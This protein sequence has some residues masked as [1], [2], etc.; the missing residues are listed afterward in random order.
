MNSFS[1]F[2][3]A[4]LLLL[5]SAACPT[6]QAGL[7]SFE[8]G[9]GYHISLDGGV[10]SSQALIDAGEF[11]LNGF[12]PTAEYY[13]VSLAAVAPDFRYGP[14]VSRYNAGA[15][16]GGLPLDIK[17]NSGLWTSLYGGR[18]V[19]DDFGGPWD[20][21]GSDYAAATSVKAH[22]GEHSLALRAMDERLV[23]DYTLDSL[24][25]AA[26]ASSFQLSFWLDPSADDNGYVSNV[27]D[28]ALND[29]NGAVLFELGYSGDDFLQYRLHGETDWT[30]TDLHLGNNGWS[31]VSLLVNAESDSFSLSSESFDDDLGLLTAN[32]TLIAD[33]AMGIH[34][35]QLNSLTW[36]LEGGYLDNTTMNSAN[37]FDDF[38]MTV[39]VVPEPGSALLLALSVVGL[40]RRR[41]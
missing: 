14:D 1:R 16:S 2:F 28:L 10:T 15:Y 11:T 25:K 23:Y 26:T 12:L 6:V 13:N 40:L 31:E 30:T 36:N 33:A 41:R 37:Y 19:E 3:F 22:S 20:G 34:S 7:G 35:N 17:D 24:E 39:A 27:F 32:R 9:D 5:I 21:W 38:T 29:A 4:P 18:Q 8:S